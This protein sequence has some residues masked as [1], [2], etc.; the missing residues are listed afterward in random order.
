LSPGYEPECGIEVHEWYGLN[1][2]KDRTTCSESFTTVAWVLERNLV[3]QAAFN[4]GSICPGVS[5]S[6]VRRVGNA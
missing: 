3:E 5:N 4:P 1:V 6:G 2:G